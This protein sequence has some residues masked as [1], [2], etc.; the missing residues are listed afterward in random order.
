M[1]IREIIMNTAGGVF[2]AGTRSGRNRPNSK[3]DDEDEFSFSDTLSSL[4]SVLLVGIG[5]DG[6]SIMKKVAPKRQAA[7][8]IAAVR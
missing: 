7:A 4:C 2:A 3:R 1:N 6:S 8:N 5:G